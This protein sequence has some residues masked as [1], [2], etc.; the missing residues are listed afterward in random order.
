VSAS[1]P[2]TNS[3]SRAWIEALLELLP[4]PVILVDPETVDVTY[5]NRAA[6]RLAGGRFPRGS[7][8]YGSGG[9][10][11]LPRSAETGEPLRKEESASWMA[12]K[13]G[14]RI[15]GFHFDFDTPGGQRSLVASADLLPAIGNMEPAVIVTFEDVTELSQAQRT[16]AS[17]NA[18][19]DTLFSSAPI[20]LAY[21][22]TDLRFLRVNDALAT[23]NG[24]PAADHIGRA[25]P[26][27]L[28]HLAP[29]VVDSLRSVMES[30][31]PIANVEVQGETPSRS[32]ERTFLAGYY[33]VYDSDGEPL[34]VG[35]V[36][37]DISARKAVEA[38]RERALAAERAARAVAEAAATRERFL[39]EAS[40]LLDRSLDYGETLLSLAQLSVPDLA[41]WCAVDLIEQGE[42][43]NVAV[44]HADPDRVEFG[45]RLLRD[46]SYPADTPNGPPEVVR[47][48]RSQLLREVTDAMLVANSR[49][50]EH[51]EMLRELG[52][53]SMMVVP[54]ISRSRTL[55]TLTFLTAE[56]GRVFGDDDVLLA[57]DLARRAAVA[58][59]NAR[60]YSERAHIART[61]QESLL[62][63]ELPTIP[64]VE[65]AARYVAAGEGIDVGGDFYDVFDLGG[66]GWSVVVGDVCGKGPDAAALTAL[67]RYTLRATAAQAQLPSQALRLL[68]DAVLRQRDDGRFI[69]VAYARLNT[70]PDG[71][72]RVTLSSGGHPPPI[73]LRADGSATPVGCP[74]T[75][76]GVVPEPV[77]GDE[78]F[79]LH[80]GDALFLY[81]D[82]VTEAHA[83]E[84]I[85]DSEDIARMLE[86][87][88]GTDAAALVNHVEEVVRSLGVGAPHDDIA[89][90][91]VRVPDAPNGT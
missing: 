5:A 91:A 70:G 60:L 90:L 24:V 89:M 12:A 43:R 72:V 39:A 59:D 55:G 53:R 23:I 36:I 10:G 82:G 84:R 74:G 63:P 25:L 18:L 41:D 52:L 29:T 16:S 31:E 81:T 34:G 15:E 51:L 11:Y 2:Q 68:N 67:A 46:Y 54:M 1:A 86:D 87:W 80:P 35:S 78:S 40:V 4:T 7:G 27:V 8:R 58:I 64:G 65:V 44:S 73:L 21:M 76:L 88:P 32:G 49:T 19:L 13:T 61:L 71:G 57:E 9:S 3:D 20:G 83:P 33:P 85:L 69:T 30:G 62:P 26:D 14:R 48:G 28:P 6:D 56:S 66:G 45:E 77:L 38:E 50:P 17:A 42:L 75:L 47:S 37:V 79:E 22:D